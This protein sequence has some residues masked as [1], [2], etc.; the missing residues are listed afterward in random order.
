MVASQSDDDF[1]EFFRR[2]FPR[3]VAVARRVTVDDAGA[4][5]AALIALE[6]AYS[7]WTRVRPLEWRDAWVLRVTLNEAIR[8]AR[9][10]PL[11]APSQPS[12]DETAL[13]DLRDALLEALQLLPRRQR[14]TITLRYLTDLSELEVADVLHISRGSVKTHLHRGL[15]ALRGNSFGLITAEVLDANPL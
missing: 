3:A 8:Q 6:R 10:L 1:D 15:A 7:R 14:E 12:P 5:D 2:M 9:P 13:V 11:A 4:K